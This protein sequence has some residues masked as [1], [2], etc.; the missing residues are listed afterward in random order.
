M[1]TADPA[2]GGALQFHSSRN[3]QAAKGRRWV[4]VGMGL[5][6]LMGGASSGFSKAFLIG[7]AAVIA[8]LAVLDWFI[9]RP[10]TRAHRVVAT[11]TDQA[12]ESALFNGQAKRFAWDEIVQA[13][14]APV[15]SQ[16]VLQLQLR[17]SPGRPD[18]RSFWN[19]ANPC[20]PT[21]PLGFLEAGDQEKLLDAVN[22]R[23]ASAPAARNVLA[24]ERV[25]AEKL[26]AL[27]P[28]TWVTWG[29][30]ALN[31]AIWGA[32]VAMGASAV[33]GDPVQLLLWGG[34]SASE[35]QQGQ[36]WR[37]LS[38]AFLHSGYLHVLMNMLGLFTIGMVVERIYGH[39]QF[40][41]LYLGAA[42]VGSA[43]SLHF[44]AQKVVSVGASGAVFGVA[45]A[46]LVA[47][48]HHRKRLPELFGRQTLGGTG[49]FVAY[50][51]FQGWTSPA[52]DNAAHVGGLLA[53]MALAWILPERFDMARYRL[54]V[55]RRV[56]LASAAVAV[57][58][59][60]IAIAAPRA[61]YDLSDYHASVAAFDKAMRE[62]AEASRALGQEEAD[63]KAGRLSEIVADERT[64]TVHAPR[65]RAVQKQL[66]AIRM[67]AGDPR[68]PV[69]AAYRRLVD[70]VVENLSME[71]VIVDGKPMPADAARAAALEREA[72]Q[73]QAQMQQ[74]S[75]DW[76]R[77]TQ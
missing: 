60:G 40:L 61:P 62:L 24:E 39:K 55:R 5:G 32:T 36:W 14:I 43:A 74:M 47:V 17:P 33:R 42:L 16:S 19:G 41:L 44:S 59:L 53:G 68:V 65:W 77:R 69:L 21:L 30:V 46:L 15:Q 70:L 75:E 52:V 64:R 29:L 38:A 57:A 66:A 6:L 71:S 37:L 31:V 49:F 22:A 63:A 51:L 10:Q 48:F 7:A 9:M 20:R 12:L 3:S 4:W 11:L 45:G 50:S 73:L 56:L 76:K 67:P 2:P 72:Q 58:T 18:R 26:R 27:A 23:L 13:S 28:R 25:F 54:A 8:L 35:V 34:N 1:I